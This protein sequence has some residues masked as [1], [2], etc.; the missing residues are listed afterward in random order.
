M[1]PR[2][3]RVDGG[4]DHARV[5]LALGEP[6]A[7]PVRSGWAGA[8]HRGR[9]NGGK[10]VRKRGR[11]MKICRVKY[12]VDF[13]GFFIEKRAY[14]PLRWN[15]LEHEDSTVYSREQMS[16]GEAFSLE[17]RTVRGCSLVRARFTQSV[18][19]QW[20]EN[21]GFTGEVAKPS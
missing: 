18:S 11:G 16:G 8:P 14:A 12:Y 15:H 4:V 10:V 5:V 6:R 19:D 7:A 20:F 1:L 17:L 9:G 13:G 3:G 21:R 2:S